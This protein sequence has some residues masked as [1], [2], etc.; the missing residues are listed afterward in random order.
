MPGG[1][2]KTRITVAVEPAL[3]RALDGQAKSRNTSRSAAV[4]E[5]LTEWLR[6]R[7]EEDAEALYRLDG[8]GGGAR[9]DG[10]DEAEITARMVLEAMRYQFPA[11][12]EITDEDLRRW[13]LEARAEARAEADTEAH[14][15]N[16]RGA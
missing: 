15:R 4:E 14:R 7:M 12:R 6:R 1:R 3:V 16:G 9:R 2:T 10:A 5:A 11:M 13:A 8:R